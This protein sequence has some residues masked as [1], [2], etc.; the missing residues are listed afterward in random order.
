MSELDR[1]HLVQESFMKKGPTVEGRIQLPSAIGHGHLTFLKQ[2]WLL[3][4]VIRD[5]LS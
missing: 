3:V 5:I 2:I 1:V 4:G